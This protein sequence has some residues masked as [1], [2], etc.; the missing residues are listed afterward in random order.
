MGGGAGTQTNFILSRV[1]TPLPW[2]RC[3]PE[4]WKKTRS[5][6]L[7][8]YLFL[9]SDF[10][11]VWMFLPCGCSTLTRHWSGYP[12]PVIDLDKL[13]VRRWKLERSDPQT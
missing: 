7:R 6:V 3:G 12:K 5:P 8:F 10:T 11:P 13:S 9:L 1:K 2:G 4:A